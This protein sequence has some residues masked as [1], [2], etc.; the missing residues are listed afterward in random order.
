M[1]SE[2]RLLGVVEVVRVSPDG[3]KVARLVPDDVRKPGT[4]QRWLAVWFVEHVGLTVELLTDD[5]VADWTEH[6]LVVSL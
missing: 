3:H 2:M 5:Q 6:E 4:P 1:V